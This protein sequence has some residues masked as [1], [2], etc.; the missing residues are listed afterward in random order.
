MG[1]DVAKAHLD[2]A[3]HPTGQTWQVSHEP[4][5]IIELITEL[6]SLR[7]DLMVLEATG[8]L[9]MSLVGGLVCAQLPVEGRVVTGDAQFTQRGGSREIV[10]QGGTTSGR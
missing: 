9:E 10:A 1:I 7:P 8:G 2:I 5:G 6:K 4:E 3:V